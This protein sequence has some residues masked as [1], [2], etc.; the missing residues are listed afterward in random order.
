[1]ITNILIATDGSELA[2]RAVQEGVTLARQTGAKVTALTVFP[3]FHTFSMRAAAVQDTPEQYRSH[4]Q[5]ESGKALSAVTQAATAAGVECETIIEE[6]DHPY[7]AIIDTA[8]SKGCDLVVM[9]SH[10]RH[11][12]D[13]I[14][15]ASETFKV[16]THSDIPVLV[17]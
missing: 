7:Q 6:N 9:A 16:L 13:G 2:S 17:S 5:A 12:L 1:M 4:M 15:H 10:R 3:P 8:K 11:G 14:L